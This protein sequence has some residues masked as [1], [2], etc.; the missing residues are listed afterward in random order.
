MLVALRSD[1]VDDLKTMGILP[2]P[3]RWDF[4]NC[5]VA[6]QKVVVQDSI[7]LC[8]AGHGWRY[9]PVRHMLIQE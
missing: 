4:V 7:N 3:L 1:E 9:D 2:P 8:M 5:A 6:E